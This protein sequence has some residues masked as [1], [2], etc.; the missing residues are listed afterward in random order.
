[1]ILITGTTGL[2]GTHLLAKLLE[3]TKPEEIRGLYRTQ[4]KKSF[5]LAVIQRVYGKTRANLAAD[6]NWQKADI[7]QIPELERCFKNIVYVYHCA[8]LISN[9]PSMLKL[10]R[11]VNIEGT[12]NVVNLAVDHKVQKLCHVSSI[13]TL[14]K[15]KDHGVVDEESFRENLNNSSHY[16]IAKYGG[17]M[18]VWRASQEG[19]DVV[20][21]N[22][23]IILGEGFY[24]EGSGALF[25]QAAS[26]FPFKIKKITGF[27]GVKDVADVMILA[28][29]SKVKN[30]RFILV[31]KNTRISNV[32]IQIAE[33]LKT[34]PPNFQLKKWMLY[35]YWFFDML[36]SKLLGQQRK[37]SLDVIPTLLEDRRYS[38]EKIESE[39]NFQFTPIE[40]VII[41][42]CEDFKKVN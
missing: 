14:G 6:I 13:A 33:K 26:K 22:P 17:E 42:C 38:N 35:L 30:Q 36:F 21:V 9:S 25:E 27:V 7:N 18:E 24:K 11:K 10:L 16:S 2:V 39:F 29:L 37:L 31:E 8:G 19:L 12:A 41:S 23:G 15:S 3:K 20:I 28:M 34:K 40:K 32:Q 1:M 4:D 5:C